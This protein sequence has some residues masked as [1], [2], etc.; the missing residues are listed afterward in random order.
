MIGNALARGIYFGLLGW[1]LE[2]NFPKLPKYLVAVV[3]H[4]SW[5]DFFVGL[6]VRSITREK[7]NF[8]GKKELFGPL[9][10]WFFKSLGGA[11]I[12]RSGGKGNVEGIV[13]LYASR[14]VFRLA[15]APEGTRKKVS[16]L[17]TG[18]Y[19]I[20]QQAGVPII[21]VTFDYKNKK[22]SIHPPFYSTDSQSEDFKFLEGIFK[23]VVG[24]NADKSF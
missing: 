5:L 3:P 8:I 22:V 14:N 4:T 16:Q 9:T 23:G 2:G 18:F 6:M 24:Y 15:L 21:P 19:H 11:S 12:D 17:K 1:K 20:A 7:I 10:A 13:S